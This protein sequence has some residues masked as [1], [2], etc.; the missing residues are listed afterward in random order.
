M[1]SSSFYFTMK[2]QRVYRCIRPHTPEE[3]GIST[4]RFDSQ[5]RL[6]TFWEIIFLTNNHTFVHICR[7]K[8]SFT[9]SF[10]IWAANQ[11]SYHSIYYTKYNV[12]WDYAYKI[13]AIVFMF[14][15]IYIYSKFKY[16]ENVIIFITIHIHN[17]IIFFRKTVKYLYILLEFT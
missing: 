16:F 2:A 12:Y 7:W 14:T 3:Q 15:T 1:Q 11:N 10:H 4:S 13:Q 17:E 9:T 5:A 6:P 8:N